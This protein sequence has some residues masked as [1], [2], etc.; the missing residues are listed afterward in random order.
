[1]FRARL[2]HWLKDRNQT[3]RAV[4]ASARR[5]RNR[6]L[7]A[8]ALEDR[9]LLAVALVTDHG[10]SILKNVEVETVYW[11]WNTPAL[12]AMAS[13]LNTFVADLTGSAYWSDL[14]QYG[15]GYGSWS[16]EF[17]IGGA[18]PQTT[19]GLGGLGVTTNADVEATLS[20]NLGQTN[21]AGQTLPVPNPA[22][23]LYLVFMPP[24]DPFNFTDGTGAY[25]VAASYNVAGSNV[26]PP[27]MVFGGQHAWN[28]ANS[29]AYA[30]V[31]FPGPVGGGFSNTISADADSVLS[32]LTAVSSHELVE[33]STDAEAYVNPNGTSTAFGW[34]FTPPGAGPGWT[35]GG[36]EIGD[37]LTGDDVWYTMS[38]YLNPA[39]A[40]TWF[41]QL[42]WSNFIP[43]STDPHD[44]PLAAPKQPTIFKP[45]PPTSSSPTPPRPKPPAQPPLPNKTSPTPPTH[46]GP[47]IP[48]GASLVQPTI[49]ASPANPNDLAVASQNGAVISTNAGA[50]WSTVIPFPTASSGDSSLAYTK[51]G[52]LFWSYL[53]PTT[54]GIEIVTLN[55]STG[56][57]TAGPFTVDAPASGS[58]DVQQDLAADNPQGSTTSNNLA[59]V[60]TQLGP[61]GS[62]KILLSISSN[63]GKTWLAPVTVAASSGG[64]P[65]TY[66]YGATVT[67]AP[68]GSIAL[69]YHSQ[70]GYTVAGDGGI[71]PNGTSGQTLAAIYNYNSATPNLTQQ[72][73]TI[74][75]F[76][77]GQSDITFNDQS[78]SRKI[79]GTTFLTQGSV[80]PQVLVDPTQPGVMYVVSVEDPD[81]GTSNPP[82]SEVV[83]ATLTQGINGTWSTA[84]SVIAPPSSS[85]VFQ[86][87]PTASI[88]AV[89]DIVVSWYTNQS[90]VKNAAGDYLLDTYATYSVDGGQTWA[91]PFAVDSQAFD[92]DAGA[93]KVLS[94]PPATT[95]IGNSFGVAIDG[96]NVFVAND[97]NSYTG[98]TPTGQQV[99]VESFALPGTLIVTT[100]LG[101]NVITIRQTSSDSGVDEVL[102]NGVVVS[103]TPIASLSGGI[104]I[105]TGFGVDGDEDQSPANLANDTLILDYSNGDPVPAGGVA[106]NAAS[107]G[108][109]L[110]EVNADANDTLSD[111]S[112]TISGNSVTGTDMVTLDNVVVAQLT[113]GPSNDTFT[114]NGWSGT[115]TITGGSGTNALVVAAGTVQTS[116]LTVS[117]VQT[118]NVTGGTL[119]VNSSFSSIATVQVQGPGILELDN[120]VTLTANVTNAGTLTL[121]GT[122]IASATIA[123]NYTQTSAGTLDIK[124]GGASSGQ[125]DQL[126][127]TGN[128]SLAGTLNVSLVNGFMPTQGQT[129]QILTYMGTLA[130]DF[131]TENFPPLSGGNTFKTSSGSGSYTLTVTM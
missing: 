25:T 71:V 39:I 45:T 93:A 43:L 54:G 9:Q 50:S 86:L 37:P 112:L 62:S 12:K 100:G 124:L 18:P 24:G 20:A 63:Q 29:F 114:L 10:G 26:P 72:G 15:V 113:G 64:T 7:A 111:S 84:T 129:F 38:N 122:Q 91:T 13:Q 16:G 125:Y 5:G 33:A 2:S 22:S 3:R 57:V 78:G 92:P 97:A 65:P 17:D 123:G 106:F 35:G 98:A 120:G 118:L 105:G 44:W 116:T 6:T 61:S 102:V 34:Y 67:F 49:V 21:G 79:S 130:G 95:G 66:Y 53:D 109:N 48:G 58:T 36:T 42:Y 23:T 121:G 131:S 59:I 73:S 28:V 4:R 56:A 110:I 11:N 27:W 126:H 60:W 76:G 75:A 47:S 69:A 119:D 89:G 88:G 90:G 52:T 70:P 128:V 82:Y 74:T 104:Q 99:A 96:A 85:S 87:F 115:T 127:V 101:N 46:T 68:N 83:I 81:A 41:V 77:A 1:M 80:I 107:G 51:S 103:L 14:A 8:E 94:G 31:P 55:P 32:F 19:L 30:V 108:T 117:H 40:D